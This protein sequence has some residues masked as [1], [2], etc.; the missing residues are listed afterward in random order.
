MMLRWA[1]G[2]PSQRCDAGGQ[3]DATIEVTGDVVMGRGADPVII[4]VVV[5]C[6]RLPTSDFNG[7]G[8]NDRLEWR[9]GQGG[10]RDLHGGLERIC[11]MASVSDQRPRTI[12][13]AVGLFRQGELRLALRATIFVGHGEESTPHATAVG[14]PAC[15]RTT[16]HTIS[17]KA[18]GVKKAKP[19]RGT[20][21]IVPP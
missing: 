16:P 13:G 21:V 14:D 6:V 20:A 7:K 8:Q 9:Q 10:N 5:I 17:R 11:K 12:G 19:F 4:A 1:Q 18:G 15:P 2:G 3:R